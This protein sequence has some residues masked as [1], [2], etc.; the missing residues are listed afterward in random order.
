MYGQPQVPTQLTHLGLVRYQVDKLTAEDADDICPLL[1]PCTLS[2]CPS[3]S[4]FSKLVLQLSSDS[5]YTRRQ[6]LLNLL[7]AR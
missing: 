6:L 4:T 5:A 1:L 2:G 7:I 3:F